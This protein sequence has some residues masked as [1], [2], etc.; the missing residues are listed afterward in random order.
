MDGSRAG[1]RVKRTT[2]YKKKKTK[3]KKKHPNVTLENKVI[4]KNGISTFDYSIYRPV[5]GCSIGSASG[6]ACVQNRSLFDT[7]YN[8][9]FCYNHVIIDR[10]LA[11][12]SQRNIMTFLTVELHARAESNSPT[13]CV[14]LELT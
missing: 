2:L 12:R 8:E 3:K 9:M 11:V 7:N 1:N 5:L 14:E 4:P 6:R 13:L 10:R